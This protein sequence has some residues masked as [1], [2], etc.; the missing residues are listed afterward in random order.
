MVIARICLEEFVFWPEVTYH[1]FHGL[2]SLDLQRTCEPVLQRDAERWFSLPSRG[3]AV[4][5][6]NITSQEEKY[7][8]FFVYFNISSQFHPGLPSSS[9]ASYSSLEG[10]DSPVKLS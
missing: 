6:R 2:T 3:C 10:R 4:D 7:R 5:Y 9:S 8:T 1:Q